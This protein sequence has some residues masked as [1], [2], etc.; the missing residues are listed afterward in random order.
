MRAFAQPQTAPE[1][2]V[3]FVVGIGA[4]QNAP[5]LANPVNDARAVGE[6]LRRL[7][8]DGRRGL[9]RRFPPTEPRVAGVRHQGAA[10]RCGGHLLC[11]PRRAGGTRELPAAG[12]CA[13][14]ARA[15]PGLRGAVARSVPWRDRAGPEA[16]HHPARRMPQQSVRRPAD[17]AR[18]PSQPWSCLGGPGA[19]GQRAAQHPGGDGDEGRP[20]RRGRQRQ[21]Q[22][23]RRGAA[24]EPADPGAGA[25]PVLP[26]RARQRAAGDEQPA[27]AVH[28]QLA[29][30]GSVLLQSASAQSAA[31]DRRPSLRWRCATMPARR[32]CRSRSRPIPTRIRSPCASPD[33]RAPARCG[34]R[35]GWSRRARS[36]AST[37]SR[38]RP[39]SRPERTLG[40]VG[41]LDILVEDGRGGSVLGSL[42]ISVVGSNRPPVA[43]ARRRLRIYTG[44]LGIAP[45]TDPD[46]DKLTVTVQGLPRGL[47]RF[48]VTTMRTGDRLAAGAIAGP[49]LCAG[50]R[51][52][53]TRGH[54]PVPGR[55]WPRRPGRGRARYRR[56]GPR[57]SGGADGGSRA[58]GAAARERP[59]GGRGNLP[60]ALSEFVSGGCGAAAARRTA[61]SEHSQGRCAA[62]SCPQ[63]GSRAPQ[64]PA[65]VQTAAKPASPPPAPPPVVAV[66]TPKAPDK[67]A[68]LQPIVP[69]AEPPPPPRRDLAMVVP[70]VA[71]PPA[72]GDDRTFQDCPT[73]VRMVRIPAGTL[74]MGQGARDPSAAAGAQGGRAVLCARRVS[75]DGRGLERLPRRWRLRTA[76]AHGGGADDT[77]LHNVSWDD[78]QLFITWMSRRAGHPY[79]LPTEAE[80]EY[81]ARAGT[82]TRYWWGDQ[83]GNGAG[84]LCRLRRHAGSACAAAG[85]QFPAQPLRPLR[86]ARVASRSGC[87]IAGSRTTAMPRATVRRASRRTA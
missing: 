64:P 54:L 85:D 42:P 18:S 81:A 61:R 34:S 75:G 31:A 30:R 35:A 16:W 87:R 6:A 28:L 44:A 43:E 55:R 78:A 45:P 13:A 80:W 25:Q 72:A 74:M 19:R 71:V 73:C 20:D 17:R 53:W 84:Q 23:L 57:R 3:A 70:P 32:R 38:R 36:T 76:A 86:H 15:R 79:R 8:F 56:H 51:L 59:G 40:D 50:A 77:P 14:R 68:A 63:H 37:A 52:Q 29:R 5:R 41:T 83:S 27:G 26:Q 39:T 60:S 67:V 10:G 47:V 58:V 7:N 9:R 69:P 11:R 21:P 82:A 48:G 66:T 33:C 12:R 22:P 24:Q 46:G 49:G 4:Y 2:R 62:A 65:P 1:R